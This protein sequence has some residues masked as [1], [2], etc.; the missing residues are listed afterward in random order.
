MQ[1][2][3][4][5]LE[6]E[7][8]LV[9]V[10]RDSNK[11]SIRHLRHREL[12][13]DLVALSFT[14]DGAVYRLLQTVRHPHLP[15]VYEVRQEGD[16]CLVLEEFLDGVTLDRMLDDGP[17]PERGVRRVTAAVCDAAGFLHD[18]G[19]I[20]RDIKPENVMLTTDGRVV[21]LDFDTAREYKPEADR[22]TR[23]IGTAGYAA[24]EQFGVTQT[25]ARADIFAIGI[26]MN[27]LLTGH[28]PTQQ[29]ATGRLAPL[30]EKCTRLDPDRRYATVWELKEKLGY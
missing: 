11:V 30:I 10:L 21:L 28:H 25:D 12:G 7:Y 23:V 13:R 15:R 22:D 27:V 9:R 4:S 19:F 20:H 1:W 2:L 3:N 14:G 18:H 26:M 29:M 16:R 6:S 8:E 17:Y 5:V 24:P